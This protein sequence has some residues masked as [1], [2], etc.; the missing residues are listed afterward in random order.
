MDNENIGRWVREYRAAQGFTS[1]E[2][3]TRL[4]I[5]KERYRNIE[6][7]TIPVTI[8]FFAKFLVL[9]DIEPID[10]FGVALL[11]Y[12]KEPVFSFNKLGNQIQKW[13]EEAGYSLRFLAD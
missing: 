7:G 4:R 5:S 13:R 12:C 8:Q 1:Q 3:S 2:V 6:N 9:F 10:F 11:F